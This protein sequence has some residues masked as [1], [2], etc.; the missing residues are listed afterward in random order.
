MKVSG[1]ESRWKNRK[2]FVQGV[3]YNSRN[4]RICDENY[5]ALNS[6]EKWRSMLNRCF[7]SSFKIRNP[8]YLDCRIS[9]DWL[10]YCNFLDWYDQQYYENGWQLDKDILFKGNKLYSEENCILVPLE[11]NNLFINRK[12]DRGDFPV[13]V[14][15]R[16]KAGNYQAGGGI[17]YLG[18]YE[19][20]EEAFLVYKTWKESKIKE[21]AEKYREVLTSKIYDSLMNYSIDITD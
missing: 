6:Y 11:I 17:N 7:N 9:D 8:S 4:L 18:V 2:R 15:Y 13:G 20:V 19:T 21:K 14:T 5:K 1:L 10:D 16:E 3:G 12:G